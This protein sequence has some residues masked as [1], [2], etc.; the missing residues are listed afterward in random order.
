M[1]SIQHTQPIRIEPQPVVS[2][3]KRRQRRHRLLKAIVLLTIPFYCIGFSL[4]AVARID[5]LLNRAAS[6]PMFLGGVLV[7]AFLLLIEPFT[8]ALTNGCA[9]GAKCASVVAAEPVSCLTVITIL[10]GIVVLAIRLL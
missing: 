3:H 4:L 8:G 10:A 1:A 7:F 5:T 9:A 6:S 2:I